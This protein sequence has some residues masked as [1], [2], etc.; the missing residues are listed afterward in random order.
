MENKGTK[1]PLEANDQE[2]IDP[3]KPRIGENRGPA[4]KNVYFIDPEDMPEV[5]VPRSPHI[6]SDDPYDPSRIFWEKIKNMESQTLQKTFSEAIAEPKL[7]LEKIRVLL[8]H[9]EIKKNSK[10]KRDTLKQAIRE[11]NFALFAIVAKHTDNLRFDF[12]SLT[13]LAIEWKRV[14]ILEVLHFRKVP[15]DMEKAKEIIHRSKS[16]FYDLMENRAPFN[17]IFENIFGL[18]KYTAFM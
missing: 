2:E 11:N 1:R 13:Q 10:L 4:L 18:I 6:F 7:N 15:F 12:D 16:G 3:K 5:Q 9:P 14:K 8:L 17:I